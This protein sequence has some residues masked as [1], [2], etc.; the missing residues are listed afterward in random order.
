[1]VSVCV[2]LMKN[3]SS[4]MLLVPSWRLD[5]SSP[6]TVLNWQIQNKRELRC[7]LEP[8]QRDDAKNEAETHDNGCRHEV[9]Q[10]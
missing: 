10:I 5:S 9:V 2:Y 3:K 8:R 4:P 6:T 7:L 1:M